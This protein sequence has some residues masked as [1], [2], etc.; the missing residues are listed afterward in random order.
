LCYS[1]E[2]KQVD[3]KQTQQHRQHFNLSESA[4]Q[5]LEE[6][7][8]QRYPGKQRRQS[9]LVEDLITE[10]FAKERSMGTA[11]FSTQNPEP[12]RLAPETQEA[13]NLAQQEAV[14]MGANQVHLEHLL[15]GVIAQGQSKAARWLCFSGMDMPAVRVRAT[16]V[17]GAHYTD[18]GNGNITF[19]TE[20][21]QCLAIAVRQLEIAHSLPI[22]PEHLVMVVLCHSEMK[23]F[24]EPWASSLNRLR[25]QLAE[26]VPELIMPVQQEYGQ[27]SGSG[28]MKWF[29]ARRKPDQLVPITFANV[30]GLQDVK[31]Q[32]QVVVERLRNKAQDASGDAMRVALIGPASRERTTIIGAIAGEAKVPLFYIAGSTLLEMVSGLRQRGDF[33]LP[34]EEYAAFRSGGE[35]EYIHYVFAEAKRFAPALLWLDE[36]A[37]ITRLARSE[38]RERVFEQLLTE[39]DGIDD[40]SRVVLITTTNQPEILD[41]EA[42][43][44]SHFNRRIFMEPSQPQIMSIKLTSPLFRQRVA[45]TMGSYAAAPSSGPVRL[46]P[47]CKREMQSGWRH[48]V[49]C[50]TSLSLVCAKCG[51]PRPEIEGARFCFECGSA[52]E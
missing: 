47:S 29:Y 30:P 21:Y 49:Y 46:C 15:L 14:N 28:I 52:F 25:K 50:G 43:L 1:E 5:M 10:A 4:K 7:T 44:L 9:Q 33:G 8:A 39:I 24:L 35:Q 51:T 27:E 42:F 17:F 19:S 36:L 26:I 3:G 11:T 32:L 20:S 6:L 45:E 22:V 16:E 48:C 34:A 40:R 31:Q 18:T 2:V 12:D 23:T 37:A 41:N 38:R 13:L